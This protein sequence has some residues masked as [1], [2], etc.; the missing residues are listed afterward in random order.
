MDPQLDKKTGF[1]RQLGKIKSCFLGFEDHGIFTFWL[2]VDYGGCCQSVGARVLSYRDE[3]SLPGAL[4]FII[5]IIKAC[6]VR[7][8]DQVAGR[9]VYF[10]WSSE[11]PWNMSPLGIQNLEIDPGELFLFEEVNERVKK[12][13]D[14]LRT[15]QG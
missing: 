1:Y 14:L 10:L 3:K 5:R 4:D 7:S 2:E 8:W 13:E 9:T 15:T 11:K 12:L 6:G